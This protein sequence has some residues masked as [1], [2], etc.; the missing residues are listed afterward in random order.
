MTNS[1]WTELERLAGEAQQVL[2]EGRRSISASKTVNTF[3]AAS[4]PTTILELLAEL[5]RLQAERDRAIE[6]L[7]PFA[8]PIPKSACAH[9]KACFRWTCED[10]KNDM[11]WP[12]EVT[13]GD[14]RTAQDTL[15]ALRGESEID[16][17]EGET[18]R[19]INGV[20]VYRS[21]GDMVDD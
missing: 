20:K 15:K 4:D 3:D 6:V 1:K 10:S 18:F 8:G 7:E 21:Y 19:F 14:L 16:W 12:S 17:K 13:V 9:S 5:K 11:T 2:E